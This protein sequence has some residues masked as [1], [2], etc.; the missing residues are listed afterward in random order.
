MKTDYTN[1]IKTLIEADSEGRDQD[2]TKIATF[3]IVEFLNRQARI[4]KM[5]AQIAQDL[6]PE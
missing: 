1:D 2:V 6:S 5:L 4:E 3:L